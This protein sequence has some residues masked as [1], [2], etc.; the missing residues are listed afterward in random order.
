VYD[1]FKLELADGSNQ[2]ESLGTNYK[3]R[4]NVFE[5]SLLPYDLTLNKLLNYTISLVEWGASTLNNQAELLDSFVLFQ[6]YVIR[7][8]NNG[9]DRISKI[10]HNVLRTNVVEEFR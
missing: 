1:L 9:N 7:N 5:E 10:P 8:M 2:H 6:N 4:P 3:L